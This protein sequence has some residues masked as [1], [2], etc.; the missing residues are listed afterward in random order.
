MF[1]V[2]SPRLLKGR[3]HRADDCKVW[4]A[5]RPILIRC[6]A[7]VV[8]GALVAGCTVEAAGVSVVTTTNRLV[9]YDESAGTLEVLDD[10]LNV[11]RTIPVT[12]AGL[13]MPRGVDGSALVDVRIDGL[14]VYD[15]RMGTT[16]DLPIDDEGLELK[17]GTPV[18]SSWKLID[19]PVGGGVFAVNVE[20]GEYQDV[21]KQHGLEDWLHLSRFGT[22]LYV[23]ELRD[24][25]LAITIEGDQLE[26]HLVDGFLVAKSG[27]LEVTAETTKSGETS[28]WRLTL[29]RDGHQIGGPLALAVNNMI[30]VELIDDSSALTV[31]DGTI[32]V[33]NFATGV[34]REIANFP[35]A[36]NIWITSPDRIW[37]ARDEQPTLLIDG[38]GKTVAEFPAGMYPIAARGGCSLLTQWNVQQTSLVDNGSGRTITTFDLGPEDFFGADD[39]TTWSGGIHA[40]LVIDGR[41]VDLG[42]AAYVVDLSANGHQAIVFGND[43]PVLLDT[44]TRNQTPLPDGEYRFAEL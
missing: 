31:I 22:G 29:S 9:R 33:H 4:C 24:H 23:A 38:A 34:D 30:R 39:C 10:Q 12:H 42:F 28:E 35:E 25:S 19:R 2:R 17:S 8:L 40:K 11:E 1:E 44:V 3:R 7:A 15:L 20:T 18:D 6:I 13:T 36:S 43:G 27:L 37:I 14:T 21:R 5:G 41:V 16:F 26:H 32:S